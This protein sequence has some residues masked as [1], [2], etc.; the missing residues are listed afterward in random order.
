MPD[1]PTFVTDWLRKCEM[2]GAHV[3]VILKIT[4]L[5]QLK[6]TQINKGVWKSA[7]LAMKAVH[8]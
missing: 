3:K 2:K 6:A 8:G 1:E 7:R 5:L 4:N